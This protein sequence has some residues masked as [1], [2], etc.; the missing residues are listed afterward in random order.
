M[1][2]NAQHMAWFIAGLVVILSIFRPGY[3]NYL[4]M[5]L[6]VVIAAVIQVLYWYKEGRYEEHT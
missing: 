2:K 5:V 1:W 6:I 3:V 4:W